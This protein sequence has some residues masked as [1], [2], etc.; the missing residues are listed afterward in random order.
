MEEG[1]DSLFKE[2][3]NIF[4]KVIEENFSIIKKEVAVNIQEA[5]RTPDRLGQ[6]RNNNLSHNN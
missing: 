1:E 6:K 2:P 5:Y 4:D 3:E